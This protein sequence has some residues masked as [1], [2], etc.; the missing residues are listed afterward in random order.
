MRGGSS[1]GEQWICIP[2]IRV[3]I[4]VAPPSGYSSMVEPEISNLKIGVRISIPAPT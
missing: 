4:P 1:M 3:R 2:P